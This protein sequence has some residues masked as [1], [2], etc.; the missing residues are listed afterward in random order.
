MTTTSEAG[1]GGGHE[2]AEPGGLAVEQDGY[3]LEQERDSYTSGSVEPYVFRIVGPDGDRPG[4]RAEHERR[5]HLIVA[6]RSPSKAFLHLHPEQRDD[7]S[8]ETPLVAGARLVPGLRGLHDRR[9]APDARRRPRRRRRPAGGRRGGP[10]AYDVARSRH[11]PAHVPRHRGRQAGRDPAVPR[12]AR[13]PRGAARGDLAYVHAHAD[14]D[15]LSFDVPFPGEGRYGSTSSS[16]SASR[17]RLRVSRWTPSAEARLPIEGMTCASAPSGREEA[18]QAR[19]FRGCQLRDRA[20]LRSLTLARS[21]RS[22]R[23]SRRVGRL[24]AP[25][26]EPPPMPWKDPPRRSASGC[27]SRRC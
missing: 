27:S 3:R 17:S 9:G 7:G 19:G 22:S 15:E 1:H 26:T 4:L 14:E 21:C 16:G 20:R 6:G 23:R 2:P 18:E 11:W 25:P 10:H 13:P 24:R 12:R 8:W 5:L